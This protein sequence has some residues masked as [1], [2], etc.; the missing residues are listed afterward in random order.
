[1][2]HIKHKEDNRKGD[3]AEYYAITWLWDQGYEVFHNSGCTGPVDIIAMDKEG[4]LILIDVKT[5]TTHSDY[6]NTDKVKE[7]LQVTAP[8]TKVQQKLGVKLLS[9][10]PHT[11]KLRFIKHRKNDD[12]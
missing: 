6:S 1:M 3:M 2:K 12:K 11:R 4:K 5:A 9:Y 10:N 7:H 8:R